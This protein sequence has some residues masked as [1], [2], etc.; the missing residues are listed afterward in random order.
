[1]L[2]LIKNLVSAKGP[3][4]LVHFITNKCNANCAHCFIYSREVHSRYKGREMSLEEIK[5]AVKSLSSTL[6]SVSL[7]GGEPFIRPDINEIVNLYAQVAKVESINITT[8]A[9]IPKL[10]STSVEKMLKDNPKTN[11]SITLSIDNLGKKHDENRRVPG[12]F[13]K[14]VKT[15][16]VLAKIKSDKLTIN[17]NLTVTP[18]NERDLN[19]IYKYLVMK[20]GAKSLALTA[21]RF[22]PRC[23][24]A[25]F[26]SSSYSQMNGL[27]NR[28]FLTGKLKGQHGFMGADFYNAKNMLMRDTVEKTV[29]E[30]RFLHYCQAGKLVG[31]LNANGDVY[32]CELLDKKMGNLRKFNYSFPK[33][34]KRKMTRNIQEFIRDTKC[35]C[36]YECFMGVN[37]LKDPRTYPMIMANY[38]KIKVAK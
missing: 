3:I 30:K 26:A 23:L 5:R 33:I 1:M 24:G 18:K 28:G 14:L 35:Y 11:F 34:W 31:I 10:I 29:R 2:K 27:V 13:S 32:P 38:L 20:L 21:L 8:N 7:T 15:Y 37:F 16:E 25:D 6:L 12:L 22:G 4:F 19:S 17:F 9:S 36:T